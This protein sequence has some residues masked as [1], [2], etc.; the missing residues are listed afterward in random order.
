[1]T[2][3]VTSFFVPC[4]R[5]A[6]KYAPAAFGPS[7]LAKSINS[8]VVS[9]SVPCC[10]IALK[11]A[12][13]A[14]FLSCWMKSI[15]FLVARACLY[16]GFSSTSAFASRLSKAFSAFCL[17]LIFFA[18]SAAS[19]LAVFSCARPGTNVNSAR[20]L[21]R[22]GTL[23][24]RRSGGL[25]ALG[26]VL[27]GSCG[28]FAFLRNRVSLVGGCLGFI[29]IGMVGFVAGRGGVG[30]G[31]GT[32]GIVLDLVVCGG[33]AAVLSAPGLGVGLDIGF[34]A[35]A[36]RGSAFSACARVRG[37]IFFLCSCL[38][39]RASASFLS[40]LSLICWVCACF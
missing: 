36:S 35:F 27:V 15:T 19:L 12:F 39:R 30:A 8:G 37:V 33:L 32:G 23:P 7:C 10:A 9:F 34:A 1:M 40:A 16:S 25:A 22:S 21:R 5:I 38:M 18:V 26:V 4:S 11:Y 3:F 17:S 6:S 24:I 31:L 14:S 13:A 28:G 2:S 20:V 29:A